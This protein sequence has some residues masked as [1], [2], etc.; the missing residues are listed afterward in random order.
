VNFTRTLLVYPLVSVALIFVL[1][2]GGGSGSAGSGG[3]PS[4]GP[5]PGTRNTV[6][7]QYV[8]PSKVMLGV[9]DSVTLVG[10]NFTVQSVV[11]FDGASIQPIFS[12]STLQ[13]LPPNEGVAQSHTVQVSDPTNGMSNVATFEVYAPQ[14]GPT[15]FNGQTTQYLSESLITNSLVPDINGDGRA[16]L[17]LVT[18]TTDSIP[19]PYADG[20]PRLWNSLASTIL[21]VPRPSRSMRRAGTTNACNGEATRPGPETKSLSFIP[22]RRSGA[23]FQKR[24]SPAAGTG[25]K[26]QVMSAVGAM[27]AAGHDKEHATGS[28]VPALAK[29]ART[30][31]PAF[32]NG[33]KP[34]KA[35]PPAGRSFA[36]PEKRPRLGMTVVVESSNG[37]T[38][39]AL[40]SLA[41]REPCS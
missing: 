4:T 28:I 32:R 13:F 37:K 10:A 1:S 26:V 21:W 38:L 36:T 40:R 15:P 34:Q 41:T 19:S 8:E 22:L 31:H 24:Q 29:S 39:P 16:D 7:I 20:W 5:G 12:N 33:K 35:A 30:G 14:L 23:R 18:P 6:Q 2:C 3:S 25:D 9:L 27:Q 17:I 11:L